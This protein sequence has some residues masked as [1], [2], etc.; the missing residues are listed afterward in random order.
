RAIP[1]EGVSRESTRGL[2]RSGRNRFHGLYSRVYHNDPGD[3]CSSGRIL[4]SV[5]VI[6]V[7]DAFDG[8]SCI[9]LIVRTALSSVQADQG[10]ACQSQGTEAPREL[11]QR[12]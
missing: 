7:S 4:C 9:H 8:L 11:E 3:C 1:G 10:S 2:P 6:T 5:A 12:E